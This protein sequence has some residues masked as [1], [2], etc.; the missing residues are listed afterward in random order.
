MPD[1]FF[2]FD[3]IALLLTLIVG[4]ALFLWTKYQPMP[5]RPYVYYSSTENLT[6]L[7][8]GWRTT[9]AFLP[10]RL[11]QIALAC[12][13]LAFLD[14][15]LMIQRIQEPS[16]L[17]TSQKTP[18][19]GIG[20]YLVVD[21]SGSMKENVWASDLNGQR[22]MLAKIDL[23]KM[24]TKEFVKQNPSNLIGLVSFARVPQV[25]SPLTLD[26]QTILNDL[27]KI[28]VV[29]NENDDGTA[30]GYAIFKT[31]NL[32]AATKFIAEEL[33]KKN[34][35]SYQIKNTI[36]ILVTDGFQD[37]NS[38]DE[39][40]KLRTMDL[41]NAASYAKEQ[42][43][44]LYIINVDPTIRSETFAPHRRLL[45]SITELTGGKF[46][47]VDDSTSLKDI[48]AAI[49]QLEKSAILDPEKKVSSAEDLWKRYRRLSFYPY[50]IAIGMI[51]LLISLLLETTILRRVP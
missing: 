24:V 7:N 39:G 17:T 18:T 15:H 35:L 43:V 19:E 48:Y 16:S 40:N 6:T 1:F 11:L 13:A 30:M 41:E 38:L 28:D 46:Y 20:I 42:G 25:L 22:R 27:E 3:K 37:P 49:D 51:S 34:Q 9:Y 36:L 45:T 2:S 50:L 29:K 33:K 44:R 21:Q 47:V 4:Y 23:L 26:H 10:H 12:F 31:A 32:I 14:P 5:S 8:A